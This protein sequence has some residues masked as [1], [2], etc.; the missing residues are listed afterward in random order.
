[1]ITGISKLPYYLR[2]RKW[3]LLSLQ[4]SRKRTDMLEVF[5]IINGFTDINTKLIHTSRPGRHNKSIVRHHSRLDA[6]HKLFS[7]VI[8]PWN[9]LPSNC[10]NALT[11]SKQFQNKI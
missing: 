2:L 7:R 11:N 8:K 1:M 6:H 9:T 3:G 5:K 4:D 10:A